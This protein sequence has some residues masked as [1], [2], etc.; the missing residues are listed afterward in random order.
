MHSFVINLHF[1][2][3]YQQ[4]SSVDVEICSKCLFNINVFPVYIVCAFL[5]SLLKTLIH[6]CFYPAVMLLINAFNV[7]GGIYVVS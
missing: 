7:T 6:V 4:N 2:S 1:V 3:F 5:T